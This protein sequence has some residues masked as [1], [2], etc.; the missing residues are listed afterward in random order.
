MRDLHCTPRPA[1]RLYKE[2]A[3][4]RTFS[5]SLWSWAFQLPEQSVVK[6]AFWRLSVVVTSR[7]VIG[8]CQCCCFSRSAS[9]STLHSRCNSSWALQHF[10]VLK[11]QLRDNFKKGSTSDGVYFKRG[12]SIRA[13]LDVVASWLHLT[14]TITASCAWALSMQRQHS[15]IDHVLIWPLRPF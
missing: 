14:V 11:E 6:T 1:A 2:S 12:L 10:G 8:G 5:F 15:W 3:C 13:F 7:H 9:V 4:S